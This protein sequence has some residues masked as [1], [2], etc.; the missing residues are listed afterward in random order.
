MAASSP[1]DVEK[2]APG[3]PRGDGTGASAA[4]VK[5]LYEGVAYEEVPLDAMRR[6]IATR[7]IEAKQTIPHFYLTADMESA[8]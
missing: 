4:Q 5:A 2:A 7:L 1:R 3:A 6:T 8:G